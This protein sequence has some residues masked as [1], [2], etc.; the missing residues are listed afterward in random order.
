M[1]NKNKSTEKAKERN[2]KKREGKIVRK[3]NKK[4]KNKTL[5]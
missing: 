1:I 2:I 4:L 3:I 5:T